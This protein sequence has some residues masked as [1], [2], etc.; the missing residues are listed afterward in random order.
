MQREEGCMVHTG[1]DSC[2]SGRERDSLGI[3]D[4]TTAPHLNGVQGSYAW[5][6]SNH[7]TTEPSR[8]IWDS[9]D[10]I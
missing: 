10:D 3:R 9:R 7:P 8:A 2:R 5:F 4:W 1:S 6:L